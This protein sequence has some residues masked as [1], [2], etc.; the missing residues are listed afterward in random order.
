MLS[1]EAPAFL[2]PERLGALDFRPPFGTTEGAGSGGEGF[3]EVPSPTE[4]GKESGPDLTR[5]HPGGYGE[6][7]KL[8]SFPRALKTLPFG[9]SGVL[10][11]VEGLQAE[12]FAELGIKG[13]EVLASPS[14][15]PGHF[16]ERPELQNFVVWW[17]SDPFTQWDL[18]AVC[19]CE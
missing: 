10:L 8:R 18:G 7:K 13:T 9:G 5:Q 3:G 17:R 11:K 14:D 15:V 16:T 6:F 19:C 4:S 2:T 12:E 1:K